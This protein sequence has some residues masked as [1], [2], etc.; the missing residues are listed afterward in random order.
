MFAAPT[1]AST[2]YATNR[3]RDGPVKSTNTSIATDPNA[4]KIAVWGSWI[5]LSA[6]AKTAGMT[7]AARAALFSEASCGSSR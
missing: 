3:L 1:Q 7:I 5:T 4:A 6:M 2:T